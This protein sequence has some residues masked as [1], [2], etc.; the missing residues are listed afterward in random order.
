METLHEAGTRGRTSSLPRKDLPWRTF[1]SIPPA[2]AA[3]AISMCRQQG[4]SLRGGS[5]KEPSWRGC[6]IVHCYP[7]RSTPVCNTLAHLE[8]GGKTVSVTSVPR[9]L[10]TRA[11]MSVRTGACAPVGGWPCS[12]HPWT[13][14]QA[15][16]CNLQRLCSKVMP[17]VVRGQA[18]GK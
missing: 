7:A 6:C 4:R 10:C 11:H 1:G 2:S 13:G 16:H 18:A 17:A 5:H 12:P 15:P 14:V 3:V 9:R 8:L